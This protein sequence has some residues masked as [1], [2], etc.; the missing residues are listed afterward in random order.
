MYSKNAR[1]PLQGNRAGGTRLALLHVVSSGEGQMTGLRHH[2]R[3]AAVYTLILTTTA[4]QSTGGIGDILGGVLGGGGNQVSGTIQGVNT[5]TQ[6]LGITQSNGQ[7]VTLS[8]DNNTQVVY[9]NQNYPVTALEWG[10]EVTARVPSNTNNS[11]YTDLITVTRS[12]GNDTGTD[13]GT[14]DVRTYEGTVR[15]IDRT[16]GI[17]TLSTSN[18]GILT[19]SMPYNPRSNDVTRFNNLRSGDFVRIYGVM[20]NNT[21]VELRQF[22]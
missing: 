10:D 20:L 8:Y 16:T 5:R 18:M 3:A 2:A 6:Q 12:V 15:N 21:R 11:N 4:C 13:T 14:G 22:Y 17:F 1:R 19:V 7:T 9:Q